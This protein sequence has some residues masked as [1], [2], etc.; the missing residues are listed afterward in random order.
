MKR[1]L[2][3][4]DVKTS[5]KPV[6]LKGEQGLPGESGAPGERG[7]GEPGSKVWC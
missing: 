4:S 7:I 2:C 3:L 5:C 1:Y 6:V